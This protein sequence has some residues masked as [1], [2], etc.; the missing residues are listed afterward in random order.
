MK[1]DIQGEITK[2]TDDYK[3]KHLPATETDPPCPTAE[4]E[5]GVDDEVERLLDNPS[6]LLDVDID[7]IMTIFR[8][9]HFDDQYLGS[10]INFY[11]RQLAE[12]QA[13]DTV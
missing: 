7:Y 12:K 4:S 10:G 2:I 8:I 1:F 5:A 3:A 9:R 13:R 6:E 11:I